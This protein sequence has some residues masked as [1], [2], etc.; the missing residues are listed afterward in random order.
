[1]AYQFGDDISVYIE[2]LA[3]YRAVTPNVAVVTE[4]NGYRCVVEDVQASLYQGDTRLYV[5][6]GLRM[7]VGFFTDPRGHAIW[8]GTTEVGTIHAVDLHSLTHSTRDFGVEAEIRVSPDGNYVVVV[9]VDNAA[10]ETFTA[11]LYKVVHPEKNLLYEKE[12]VPMAIWTVNA[13]EV[14][15]PPFYSS[16]NVAWEQRAAGT[17]ECSYSRGLCSHPEFSVKFETDLSS[18]EFDKWQEWL[19]EQTTSVEAEYQTFKWVW[20]LS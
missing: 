11:T 1:M 2:D 5:V 15:V 12:P 6:S 14:D 18:E 7:K 4:Y 20:L 9:A 10:Y 19:D 3:E 8:Y 16:F 17:V 13:R